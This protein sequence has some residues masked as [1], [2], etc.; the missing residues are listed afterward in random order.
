MKKFITSI[1]SFLIIINLFIPASA[2]QAAVNTPEPSK[3]EIGNAVSPDNLY[4]VSCF[5]DKLYIGVGAR[6]IIRT[7]P[8]GSTW[9]TVSIV[10]D[11]S[12]ELY[13]I[14]CTDDQ[15]IVAGTNG[16]IMRSTD[17]TDWTTIK[18]VTGNSIRK[19]IYGKKLFL[20]FT[21]K[22]G[23][24]LTSKDGLSW[25]AGKTTA[26]Q[27]I[28]DAMWNGKI[29]I[30]VG[31]NGE[32]STSK[33]GYNWQTK[34]IKNKPSFQK[35]S[36]NGKIFV[37]FG[38]TTAYTNEY[39]YTSGQYIASS[40]DGYSWS[41]K[42]L[43]TKYL[44][45]ES[46]EIYICGCQNITW[47]GKAF[48]VILQEIT[49]QAP[50][51]DT[52]LIT[53]TSNDGCDWKKAEANIYS[54]FIIE[55]SGREFVAVSNFW[56]HP[57]YYYRYEIYYSKDGVKWNKVFEAN[58]EDHK[59]N[60]II[61]GNGKFIIV[62]D[63]S[64]TRSSADGI[65]WDKDEI[66]FY[67]Q[68]WD[69][70][71]FV[72][73]DT[74]TRYIY[75]ST[76]GLVWEKGNLIDWNIS[77]DNLFWS[78]KEYVTFGSEY[79]IF[80]SKDLISWDKIKYN[81]NF[82]VYTDIGSISDSDTDG[83]RYVIAGPYGTAVSS[84]LQNWSTRKALNYYKSVI[85]GD[86]GFVAL[87]IY[88]QIDVSADGLKWKRIKIKD[89][90]NTIRKIIYAENKFIGVGTNGD[91]WYSENG[92]NWNKAESSVTKTLNDISW[93]GNEFIAVGEEGTIITSKDG[94]KWQQEVLPLK[95]NLLNIF[96][97][98]EI[99]LVNSPEGVIYKLLK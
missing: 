58:K 41:I 12:S 1:L 25:K 45:K 50:A 96:T 71:R 78:G 84:D 35:I 10:S 66:V 63:R 72:S 65:N 52:K 34:I 53:Y 28:T 19:V 14:M 47:N 92:S 4:K 54:P 18:P 6:G 99:A 7:S 68:L 91:V 11:Y 85:I 8:D 48:I 17:G 16:T 62:G 82:D 81:D 36:W 49:G 55:W 86:T 64:E 39:S 95:A 13:D 88:G 76:D 70:E 22:P 37:A 9:T 51:P 57:G 27:Y 77:Y 15:I 94:T 30:A 26:K 83:K 42:T 40:K 3:W 79:N 38:T 97:N 33:D 93:T 61:Y 90:G 59:I 60:D 5:K 56:A 46:P 80:T 44:K 67:P 98:G 2:E 89:Y 69:G 75:T 73:I 32:I 87:N 29:F 21:D 20:A 24:I 23:E 43:K 31:A 74:K